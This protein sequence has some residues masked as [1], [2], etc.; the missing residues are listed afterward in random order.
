MKPLVDSVALAPPRIVVADP[1]ADTRASYRKVLE[2]H[3]YVV[4]AAAD[5]P[6]AL[7]TAL[8]EP[9]SLVITDARLPA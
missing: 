9:V 3:G 7:V 2:S 8:S 1:D 4:S 5:G 6:G